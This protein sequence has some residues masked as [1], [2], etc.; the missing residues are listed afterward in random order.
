MQLTNLI[1]GT[2]YCFIVDDF[3]IAS[4]F[5]DIK[6]ALSNPSYNHVTI[7]YVSMTNTFVFKNEL[8]I[9]EKMFPLQ[10]IVFY[11]RS[12]E[13]E[14]T[15]AKEKIEAL[16]NSNVMKKLDFFLSGNESFI[17]NIKNI[18]NFYEINQYTIKELY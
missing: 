7:I 17:H 8:D 14:I 9:L 12:N 11:E 18:L 16:L 6:N 13:I 10:F 1:N 4:A 15:I 5:V 3:G 2:N